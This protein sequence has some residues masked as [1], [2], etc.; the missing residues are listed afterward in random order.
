MFEVV[1]KL[2]GS[3]FALVLGAVVMVPLAVNAAEADKKTERLWKSKCGSCHGND[4][5]GQTKKGKEMK[6]SDMTAADW[7][8]K[9]TDADIKKAIEEGVKETKDGVKKEMDP[10]KDELKPDQIE[11][12]V[13]Y[14]RTL[15]AK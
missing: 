10:F 14:V 9:E 7:Q 6:V 8:K 5:K 13:A 1:Q 3:W 2:R 12:L 11:A 15:A 4:G